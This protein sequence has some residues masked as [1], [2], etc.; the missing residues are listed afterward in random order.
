MAKNGFYVSH[1]N[2]THGPVSEDEIFKQLQD[3]TISFTDFIWLPDQEQWQMLAVHFM[4]KFPAPTAPPKGVKLSGA[5]K[6]AA[7]PAAAVVPEAK[8]NAVPAGPPDLK[9]YDKSAF[10]QEFGISNEQIWFVYR[11]KEKYGPYRFLEMVHLLQGQKI[12]RSD[13]IWKPGMSDSERARDVAEFGNDILSKLSDVKNFQGV[14]MDTVFIQRAFPRVP[15]DSEVILHDD[16]Q[17]VIG[18]ATTLSEGGA[19]VQVPNPVHKRGDRLKL[20]FSAAGVPVPFNCIAEVTQVCKTE[21]TGYCL[22]FIYLGQDDQKRIQKFA[23]K[24]VR[25]PLA[26]A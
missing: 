19:F 24:E 17:V 15:Y 7:A 12:E 11:N 18:A 20:H 5:A 4:E 6:P 23:E 10:N 1:C 8:E 13:F 22:K 3:N 16:Q 26:K 9:K 25:K 21:P 2:A 14:E